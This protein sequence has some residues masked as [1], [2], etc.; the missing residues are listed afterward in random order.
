MKKETVEMMTN[1]RKYSDAV[2]N[3][4]IEKYGTDA[5]VLGTPKVSYAERGNEIVRFEVEIPADIS[6]NRF[7][8]DQL[9]DASFFFEMSA[10]MEKIKETMD[11]KRPVNIQFGFSHIDGGSNGWTRQMKI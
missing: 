5:G 7:L 1:V 6:V 8:S 9:S 4:L 2:R 10:N 11:G 3:Y